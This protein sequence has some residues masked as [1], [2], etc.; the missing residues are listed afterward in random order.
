M[1]VFQMVPDEA[2]L[3]TYRLE[4]SHKWA[5]PGV[6]CDVCGWIGKTGQ[7]AYPSV[8][9][10]EEIDAKP[11]ESH[12]PVS[13]QRVRELVEPIFQVLPR[14]LPVGAG[15]EFGPLVGKL[16][17]HPPDFAWSNYSTV[18][19]TENALQKLVGLGVCGLKPVGTQIHSRAKSQK[20][21]LELEIEPRCELDPKHLPKGSLEMCDSCGVFRMQQDKTGWDEDPIIEESSIPSS[22]D[23]VRVRGL[24][25]M[26]IATKAFMNAVSEAHL[27][28][29]S[30]RELRESGSKNGT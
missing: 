8:G 1:Q 22:L 18:L 28:G 14:G 24:E 19:I 15:T 11:Y 23:L 6:K 13:P 17:G 12:W 26:I 30:F 10:P 27:R 4:A 9:L 2:S 5:L 16:T 7:P 25:G 20:I 3:D 21:Y 29:V